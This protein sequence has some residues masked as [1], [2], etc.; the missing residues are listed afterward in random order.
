MIHAR[1]STHPQCMAAGRSPVGARRRPMQTLHHP[2]AVMFTMAPDRDPPSSPGSRT[3]PTMSPVG[4]R[5]P[6][7]LARSVWSSDDTPYGKCL[8]NTDSTLRPGS[9]HRNGDTDGAAP[10]PGRSPG[11]RRHA[12]GG[13]LHHHSCAARPERGVEPRARGRRR[14]GREDP[15]S[16]GDGPRWDRG[17]AG[18][19]RRRPRGGHGHGHLGPDWPSRW[20]AG[21][22][23]TP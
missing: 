9:N 14:F 5:T 7:S 6:F 1:S 16:E 23:G 12:G 20:T 21:P 18:G 10:V 17:T 13:R 11:G 15:R 3:R 22:P 4:L 8:V 19:H 2:A